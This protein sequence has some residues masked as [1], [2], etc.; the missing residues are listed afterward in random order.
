MLA[1]DGVGCD[2]RVRWDNVIVLPEDDRPDPDGD[3]PLE[4]PPAGVHYVGDRVKVERSNGRM[5]L[6]TIVEYDEVMETYTVDTGHCVL[7]YGVEES[8]II[9]YETTDVWAGPLTRAPSGAWEGYFVGRRVRIPAMRASSD[10]D[11]KNGYIQGYNDRTGFYTV[12]LDSGLIR[13]SVLF[14]HIKVLYT[15]H[16]Y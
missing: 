11:D 8:Y 2:I 3:E 12:E 5:S 16:D 7:K 9:P 4:A 1:I 6:A 15:L 10:D 14:S 13:R